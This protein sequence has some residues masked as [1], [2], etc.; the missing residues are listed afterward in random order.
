MAGE[1]FKVKGREGHTCKGEAFMGDARA[2]TGEHARAHGRTR[3]CA[4]QTTHVATDRLRWRGWRS[5]SARPRAQGAYLVCA[6]SVRVLYSCGGGWRLPSECVLGVCLPPGIAPHACGDTPGR[7]PHRCG[8]APPRRRPRCQRRCR[9]GLGAIQ[10]GLRICV[11]RQANRSVRP[12]LERCSGA[13]ERCSG[14]F[15]RRA[16]RTHQRGGTFFAAPPCKCRAPG[17]G[18]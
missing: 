16:R 15:G 6:C 9:R 14:A 8:G 17:T 11:Y 10:Q 4:R 1:T 13:F 5:G 2:R 3:A 18:G 7:R 12:A